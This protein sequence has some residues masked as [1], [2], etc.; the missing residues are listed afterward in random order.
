MH[1]DPKFAKLKKMKSNN[2]STF[3]RSINGDDLSTIYPCMRAIDRFSCARP[4]SSRAL[5]QS[6]RDVPPVPIR[7]PERSSRIRHTRLNFD[8]Y[9]YFCT[10]YLTLANV[11]FYLWKLR[12]VTSEGACLGQL[13][14]VRCNHGVRTCSC[15]Q[16]TKMTSLV[17]MSC[18]NNK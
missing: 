3:N 4:E 11:L 8:E 1:R 2:L 13:L 12:R 18:E 14:M 9:M 7:T 17:T 6:E 16:T 10:P 5:G 15:V